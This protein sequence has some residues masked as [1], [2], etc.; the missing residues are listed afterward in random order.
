MNRISLK[1][2]IIPILLLLCFGMLY[3][4]RTGANP[5]WKDGILQFSSSDGMF[6]TRFDVRMYLDGAIYFENENEESMSDGT[7]LRRVRFAMKVKL[8]E[9]WLAEWDMDF[10]TYQKESD[11]KNKGPEVK[12]MWL[13]Y[14]LREN[15][16]IKVGH[17]KPPFSMEEL[18]S[19]SKTVFLERAYP[20]VFTTGR[21]IGFGVTYWKNWMHASAGLFG[22]SAENLDQKS[23]DEGNAFACRLVAAPLN[24]DEQLLHL[25]GAF[26]W[27]TPD[28]AEDGQE[29]LIAFDERPETSVS[30]TKF[31]DTSDI[32]DVKGYS[33]I[34]G[35]LAGKFGPFYAEAEYMLTTVMRKADKE[36]AEFCGGY[37]M[38]GW[39]VTGES[40]PYDIEEAEFGKPVPDSDLGALEIALR[41]SHLD[42]T[43][44]DAL[45]YGGMANNYGV[46]LNWYPNNNVRLMLNYIYVMNSEF[47]DGDG[48]WKGEDEFSFVTARVLVNF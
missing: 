21:R 36:D 41:Y 6:K 26:Q 43:D 2:G 34:G 30:R 24:N 12:D 42:L 44:E 25:G 13:A 39:F 4:D 8:W 23:G 17:F 10:A 18:T 33:T 9:K 35:E 11:K 19:S 37:A 7:D 46:A 14:M 16:M 27:V 22:E 5:E 3:A 29:K 1:F 48:N 20:N 32:T 38:V 31:L 40:K 45:I 15:A 28:A 47:A